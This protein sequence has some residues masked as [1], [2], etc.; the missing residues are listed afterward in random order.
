M[1]IVCGP[2]SFKESLAA[3]EAAA[4][5][6]RGIERIGLGIECDQCPIGDGGE[7]TME[8]LCRADANARKHDLTVMGPVHETVQAQFATLAGG[9]VGVI[10]LAEASGLSLVPAH[11]RNPLRTTTYGTG[12]LMRAAM[13]LGCD[14]LIVCLGGSATVDGGAGIIQALGGRF[15]DRQGQLIETPLCGGMLASIGRIEPPRGLP[16]IRVACDVRNPLHGPKGAAAVYGPQKGATESQVREL[17]SGLARFSE[18]VGVA[19]EV[20][21]AGA[22]GGAGY[23]LA[24][25]CG[26]QLERGI[27]LVLDAV[28]FDQRCRCA[29]LVL[30]GEGRLDGQ[31]LHG[32]AALG[33]AARAAKIDVPTIAIVGATG[34]G[35]EDCCD[36]RQGGMLE[37]F[38]DLSA[39]F[40]RET[41]LRDPAGCVAEAAFTIVQECIASGKGV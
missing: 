24:A 30:T 12:Q 8:A 7:G 3:A 28:R 6:A 14:E 34:P 32:K 17:E 31:S 21:G 23:G 36:P 19:G 35:A 33:V 11:H 40:G 16:R 15:F 4:A 1:R 2:D 39:R 25:L 20:E 37:S 9:K 5:M 10:E 29:A 41:A 38:V 27:E 22:A 26:A 18:V 13:D